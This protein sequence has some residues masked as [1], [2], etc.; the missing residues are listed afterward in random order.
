M[1]ANATIDIT[2]ITAP[3]KEA[4]T[5]NSKV[6]SSCSFEHVFKD[7]NDKY[8]KNNNSV[9][10]A[11]TSDSSAPEPVQNSN[12]PTK[13][14][15]NKDTQQVTE[16]SDIAGAKT[17]DT[18]RDTTSKIT[19]NTQKPQTADKPEG[20][21]NQES[22]N[23]NTKNPAEDNV[24]LTDLTQN[25]T[26][27]TAQQVNVQ[28]VLPQPQQIQPQSPPQTQKV[29]SNT[30][31]NTTGNTTTKSTE[32]AKPDDKNVQNDLDVIASKIND[33]NI[34]ILTPSA[35]PSFLAS[36]NDT[37]LSNNETKAQAQI[38]SQDQTVQLVQPQA[39][40]KQL[41]PLQDQAQVQTVITNVLQTQEQ[42]Q[43]QL[44]DLQQANNVPV[45]EVN[46][47]ALASDVNVNNDNAKQ[48]IQNIQNKNSLTQEVLDATKAKV[49]NIETPN[50]SNT[51]LGTLL[52]NQSAQ[53]QTVKLAIAN[54][55]PQAVQPAVQNS[56]EAK[57]AAPVSDAQTQG[58]V[59][60]QNTAT[61]TAKEPTQTVH[62]SVENNAF[63]EILNQTNASN[64]LENTQNQAPKEISK[65]DIA[66]QVHSQLNN[67]KPE[68]GTTKITIV[69]KPE[70]LGKI[71]IE[72]MNGKGG[73]TA[74]MTTDSPQIKEILDKHLDSLKSTLGDNG[75]NVNNV[76]VK[77][78]ETHKQ[79][80]A[81]VFDDNGQRQQQQNNKQE[82]QNGVS[83]SNER[84]E[85]TEEASSDV[86]EGS[87]LTEK[88]L[89]SEDTGQIDYRV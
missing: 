50:S 53:E 16:Q 54:N 87:E 1:A 38:S 29:T 47:E 24:V 27:M 84:S 63:S 68:E 42:P 40:A 70:N 8:S 3:T 80:N 4:S 61:N 32:C 9:E 86:P 82:Q 19:D 60:V 43:M 21:I 59:S 15:D 75:V 78:N 55:N 6:S 65:T 88:N 56:P 20:L 74:Q 41:S 46:T 48:D 5:N 22:E 79:D 49:I 14:T 62:T 52:N 13:T 44:N 73:L 18:D 58:Q 2:S 7:A 34:Q 71:N 33:A 28:E 10:N 12:A 77:V 85:T 35:L 83:S 31:G 67:L 23:L 81:F 64:Q 11:N 69:L 25:T 66:S 72:L 26:E 30:T 37:T 89:A 36:L 76:N 17:P 45:I 51:N 39:Q 57:P